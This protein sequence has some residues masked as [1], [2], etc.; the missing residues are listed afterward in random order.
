MLLYRFIN[1]SLSEGLTILVSSEHLSLFSL[2]SEQF[3]KCAKMKS[4]P[5]FSHHMIARKNFIDFQ[6]VSFWDT[7]CYF[8]LNFYRIVLHITVLMHF[9]SFE[10]CTGLLYLLFITSLTVQSP[11]KN[12]WNQQNM[13]QTVWTSEPNQM[14]KQLLSEQI[15]FCRL[16]QRIRLLLSCINSNKEHL[17]PQLHEQ[18]HSQ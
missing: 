5:V 17:H 13:F 4:K 6:S 7:S 1:S 12:D 9:T 18:E 16:K 15:P 11:S 14:Y 3:C 2:G 10:I 8:C